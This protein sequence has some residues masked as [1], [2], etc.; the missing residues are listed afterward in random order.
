MGS[1]LGEKAWNYLSNNIW[2][3]PEDYVR[4]YKIM[5]DGIF[6]YRIPRCAKSGTPTS[7]DYL[8]NEGSCNA[9]PGRS[10][11]GVP[12]YTIRIYRPK[13]ILHY[14]LGVAVIFNVHW[15]SYCVVFFVNHLLTLK[16]FNRSLLIGC[17]VFLQYINILLIPFICCS[18]IRSKSFSISQ[19]IFCCHEVFTTVNI[20][21]Y[22]I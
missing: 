9:L 1:L 2:R 18:I 15:R 16:A 7:V 5:Y 3:I 13:Y 21:C 12:I 22:I 11:F 4:W 8:L 14:I 19:L 17:F 20:L 6:F 10:I